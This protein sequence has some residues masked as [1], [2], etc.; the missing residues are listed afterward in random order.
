MKMVDGQVFQ[1]IS[2]GPSDEAIAEKIPCVLD[3]GIL[4]A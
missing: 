2:Q 3:R 4:L 1:N